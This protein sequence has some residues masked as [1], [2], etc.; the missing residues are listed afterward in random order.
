MAGATQSFDS[1]AILRLAR[2]LAAVAALL[3]ACSGAMAEAQTFR[4]TRPGS[5][6]PDLDA[7]LAAVR[8]MKTETPLPGLAI[9]LVEEAAS[10]VR[11]HVFDFTQ[12][13]YTLRLAE[14]K[15]PT[16][17]EAAD[18]MG[19]PDDLLAINGGFFERDG[20]KVLSPSGLLIINGA[21]LS[22]EQDRGGS[23]ILY[24]DGSG[25]G[26]ASRKAL[27]DR[28]AITEAVQVGPL[29]VDPGGVKG[30]YK[31]D[32]ERHNR[33]AVCLRGAS[34]TVFAVEGGI[35][36][37][38]FADL[39]SLPA[40]KGGFGCTVAINLDGGPSTQAVLSAG[41]ARIDIPGGSTVENAVIVSR[42]P[43]A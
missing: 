5:P 1:Q 37:F 42:K 27:T 39:L 29:L 15:A 43:D 3:L 20:N 36:L 28:S 26:I 23:G 11:I 6:P 12:A 14:Q 21:T 4:E 32:E 8:S 22:P 18:F 30:I 35:S 40:D 33:S 2:R 7:L 31:D 34:F 17:S 16:G 19:G 25:V 38:Q 41:S 13:G 9:G 10:G 24:V